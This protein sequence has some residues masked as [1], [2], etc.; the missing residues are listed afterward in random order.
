MESVGPAGGVQPVCVTG[1]H[2]TGTSLVA[3]LL[4]RHGLWLGEEADMM[5]ANAYNPDGYFENDR[6]VA[7]NDGILSAFGGTWSSPPALKGEWTADPRLADLKSRARALGQSLGAH[8]EVWGFKDPRAALTLPF[9]RSI[10]GD[11]KV[12]VTVR[13]PL[14]TA[15]S[16]NRRDGLTVEQGVAL[17]AAHYRSLLN[18]TTPATRIVVWYEAVCADPVGSARLLLS[19]VPGLLELDPDAVRASVREPLWHFRDTLADFERSGASSD[20]VE[21]YGLLRSE[22]INPEPQTDENEILRGIPAAIAGLDL[23]LRDVHIDLQRLAAVVSRLEVHAAQA[24]KSAAQQPVAGEPA[25]E[26]RSN[27][28]RRR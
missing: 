21:L 9:W 23:A 10:W 6:L 8:H 4:H 14:E 7:V 2:R 18:L 15:R 1:M 25:V 22:A 27:N 11:L 26:A 13:N 17:W 12:V 19:R 28:G 24:A 16:L 3:G 20:A 5:P